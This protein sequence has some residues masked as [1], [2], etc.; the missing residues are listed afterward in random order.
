MTKTGTNSNTKGIFIPGMYY[1]VDNENRVLYASDS[2]KDCKERATEPTDVILIAVSNTGSHTPS[3][4]FIAARTDKADK[5][6]L[7][8][9]K[10]VLTIYGSSV[11]LA[12]V[13]YDVGQNSI[14]DQELEQEWEKL[15]TDCRTHSKEFEIVGVPPIKGE[16]IT[17]EM[18][19][20][21]QRNRQLGKE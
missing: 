10:K 9:D 5:I 11:K 17:N 20:L 21:Q 6:V 16:D 7:D 2:F 3:Q 1:I 14:D 19:D 18:S 13:E 4:A 12:G 15:L 8:F